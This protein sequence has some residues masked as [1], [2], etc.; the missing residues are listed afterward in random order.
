M[1][2]ACAARNYEYAY[3]YYVPYRILRLRTSI[4]YTRICVCVYCVGTQ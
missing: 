3:V 1:H 2:A 4:I